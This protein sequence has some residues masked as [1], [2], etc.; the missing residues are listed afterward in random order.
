M[1]QGTVF[2]AKKDWIPAGFYF[3]FSIESSLKR[4]FCRA[5][6][7]ANFLKT[8]HTVF[9]ITHYPPLFLILPIFI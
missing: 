3:L 1:H 8:Q 7:T 2:D 6:L 5:F 9:L 4:L